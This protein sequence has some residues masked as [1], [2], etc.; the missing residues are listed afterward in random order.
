[1]AIVWVGLDDGEL[2]SAHLDGHQRKPANSRRD[3]CGALVPGRGRESTD[4]GMGND[5]VVHGRARITKKR[6]S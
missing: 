5:L 6:R 1:M 4:I 3:R 2:V